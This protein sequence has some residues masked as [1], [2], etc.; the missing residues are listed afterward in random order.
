MTLVVAVTAPKSI[1]LLAD[2]R[3]SRKGRPPRDDGRKIMFLHTPDGVGI[4]GY[5]GLGIT[6]LGKE[7]A[8]WMNAVLLG[9]S[10]PLDQSLQVLAAAIQRQI[11][12]H[13]AR[14]TGNVG[15]DHHVLI[16]AFRGNEFRLYSI[17]PVI[18]PDRKAYR[19]GHTHYVMEPRAGVRVPARLGICGD[20]ARY[21]QR[22]QTWK[23]PL[24]HV[25]RAYDRGAIS[26]R[27]VADHLARLNYEVHLANPGGSVGPRCIVGWRSRRGG[28]GGGQ[29]SYTATDRDADTPS[30]PMLGAG[31]DM[32]ALAGVVMKRLLEA[33]QAGRPCQDFPADEVN[34]DLATLPDKPDED[35]R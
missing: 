13:L 31:T 7:T 23:R 33:R 16:T 34:A 12:R 4:L 32:T 17:H 3:L 21:L 35:L 28:D 9:R 27:A 22:N 8:D 18:R 6:A 19:F 11:P 30:L 1:W 26:E 15:I 2:R 24:L 5:S 25:V 10:L 20:G 14:I 29:Q